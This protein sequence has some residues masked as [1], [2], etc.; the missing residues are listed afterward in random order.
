MRLDIPGAIEAATPATSLRLNQRN[1]RTQLANQS[2]EITV[3]TPQQFAAFIKS[4][5]AKWA[6]VFRESNI[7]VD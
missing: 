4:E 5:L 1:I 2:L 3:T 6:K 7:S